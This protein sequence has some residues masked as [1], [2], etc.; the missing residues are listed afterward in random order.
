TWCGPCLKEVP[1]LRK[2][3][4]LYRKRGLEIL[5][6]NSDQ[7][8]EKARK[9]LEKSQISWPQS[10]PEST[11]QIVDRELGVKWYPAI[12]LID[13]QRRIVF[14][15]GNGSKVLNGKKLLEKLDEALPTAPHP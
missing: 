12:I 3:A 8:V 15:S 13:P 4:E 14:I 7:K 10:N 2:A 11:K 6:M 9:F 5:G 1:V